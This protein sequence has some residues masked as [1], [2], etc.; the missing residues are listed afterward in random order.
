MLNIPH[1]QD[2]NKGFVVNKEVEKTNVTV[3]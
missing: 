1:G 2:L 3:T